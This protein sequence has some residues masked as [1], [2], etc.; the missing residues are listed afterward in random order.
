M[1][2]ESTKSYTLAQLIEMTDS[3]RKS[4]ARDFAD[5]KISYEEMMKSLVEIDDIKY[6]RQ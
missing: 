6:I 2:D 5:G 4:L 3:I 1:N